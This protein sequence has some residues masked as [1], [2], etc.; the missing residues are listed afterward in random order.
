MLSQLSWEPPNQTLL[1]LMHVEVWQ[2]VFQLLLLSDVQ[3]VL[4]C[5]DL[6]YSVTLYDSIAPPS[7]ASTIVSLCRYY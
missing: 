5:L 7:A 1:T 3:L 2:R 4:L 6:L